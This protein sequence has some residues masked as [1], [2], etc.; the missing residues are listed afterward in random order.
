MKIA[1]V[2]A[3]A[4]DGGSSAKAAFFAQEKILEKF[5][6]AIV[7]R[8]NLCEMNIHPCMGDCWCRRNSECMQDDDMKW[9]INLL[10]D[11]DL[12]LFF[13]PVFFR[14]MSSL[15]KIFTDRCYPMVKGNPGEQIPRKSGKKAILTMFQYVKGRGFEDALKH[16]S[17]VLENLGFDLK[18][19]FLF[20]DA[21]DF[22]SAGEDEKN[23]QKI[24]KALYSALGVK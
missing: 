14:D 8:V 7:A 24:L 21:D 4:R 15:M 9:I 19:E 13:S 10:E 12:T 16:T 18:G 11:A 5:P 22:G 1:I 3:S 17:W 2:N 23:R 6:D 20:R